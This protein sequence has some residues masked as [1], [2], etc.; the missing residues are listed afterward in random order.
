MKQK[1][2]FVKWDP[3]LSQKQHSSLKTQSSLTKLPF[4]SMQLQSYRA[5][6]CTLKWLSMP[7][8]TWCT[9]W[10]VTIKFIEFTVWWSWEGKKSCIPIYYVIPM[11][12]FCYVLTSRPFHLLM[13]WVDLLLLSTWSFLG[14]SGSHPTPDAPRLSKLPPLEEN[15]RK[16]NSVTQNIPWISKQYVFSHVFIKRLTDMNCKQEM[17]RKKVGR[18]PSLNFLVEPKCW[19]CKTGCFTPFLSKIIRLYRS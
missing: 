14:C 4:L 16:E 6:V 19:R 17:Q 12:L 1:C 18:K 11:T 2:E 10:P 15:D 13:N 7:E 9:V 5:F 3:C 8:Y